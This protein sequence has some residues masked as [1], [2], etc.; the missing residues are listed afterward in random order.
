MPRLNDLSRPTARQAIPQ[1]RWYQARFLH[2]YAELDTVRAE[3]SQAQDTALGGGVPSLTSTPFIAALAPPVIS[4]AANENVSNQFNLFDRFCQCLSLTDER[5]AEVLPQYLTGTAQIVYEMLTQDQRQS[6]NNVRKHLIERLSPTNPA[7]AA[8]KQLRKRKQKKKESIN[9]YAVA[10][11]RLVNEAL[12]ST[13]DETTKTEIKITL[14]LEGL[15]IQH[16][17]L[18][19]YPRPSSFDD[20]VTRARQY[21]G[22]DSSSDDSSDEGGKRV[23]KRKTI[24]DECRSQSPRLVAMYS[25][26]DI[27]YE[28]NFAEQH[29]TD[30]HPTL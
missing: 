26:D 23:S 18:V 4:G 7:D 22:L 27:D 29:Q 1:K 12:P 2:I 25:R 20:A 21:E 15:T 11:T 16:K 28:T 19:R 24:E 30:V 14:F 6:Y 3:M 10:I 17:H 8:M 13:V 9:E 5:K